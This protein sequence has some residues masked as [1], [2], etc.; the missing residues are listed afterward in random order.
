MVLAMHLRSV[1]F[2]AEISTESLDTA[3]VSNFFVPG[4]RSLYFCRL[5]IS[6]VR[7]RCTPAQL[8]SDKPTAAS[9]KLSINALGEREFIFFVLDTC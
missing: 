4:V 3:S 5:H 6:V 1:H 8:S 7:L 2:P 9:V